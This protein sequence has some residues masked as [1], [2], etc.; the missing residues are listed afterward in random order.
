[1]RSSVLTPSPRV[2][3]VHTMPRRAEKIAVSM[4]AD[5]LARAEQLRETTGESRSALVSRA[6]RRLLHAEAHAASVR[7]YVDA[8]RRVPETSIDER[9]AHRLASRSLAS[10]PWEEP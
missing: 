10:L 3:H 8:Y 5:L 7:E 6:L 2:V 4:D 1:L 9:R